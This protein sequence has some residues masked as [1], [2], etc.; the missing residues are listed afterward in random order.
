M[1]TVTSLIRALAAHEQ[2]LKEVLLQVANTALVPEKRPV[3][4]LDCPMVIKELI[5]SCW[6]G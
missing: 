6:S 2:D 3:I 1:N 4:P 5:Q